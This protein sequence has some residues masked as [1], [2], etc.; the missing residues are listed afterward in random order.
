M[1]KTL[2]AGAAGLQSLV[3]SSLG[4]T[5]WKPLT[6]ERI[7]TFADATDDHQWIHVD[8]DRIAKE[9][10]Y[11]RPLAHGYLTLSLVA[12]QFFELLDLQ[13]FKMIINYG[14][15]KVRFPSPLREGDRY[16]LT[17]SLVSATPL[18]ADPSKPD[19]YEWIE[20]VLGANIEVDGAKKPACAAEVVYRFQV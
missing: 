6:F 3:G 18:L 16:R 11:G 12:G 9:S 13:G 10:P 8:R 14:A 17:M 5:E 20:V 4:S 1:S 19:S 15:N 7:Q 2:I